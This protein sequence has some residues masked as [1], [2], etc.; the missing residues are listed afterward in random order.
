MRASAAT[1]RPVTPDSS[2]TIVV[3]A[4]VIPQAAA[5]RMKKCSF[6]TSF[7]KPDGGESLR[8]AGPR[9]VTVGVLHIDALTFGCTPAIAT[10]SDSNDEVNSRN[11]S[12]KSVTMSVTIG[13]RIRGSH[14]SGTTRTSPT[15]SL[16]TESS[17][18]KWSSADV[19]VAVSATPRRTPS[20][21]RPAKK[22]GRASPPTSN[23]ES[24][25]GSDHAIPPVRPVGIGSR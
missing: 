19:F 14:P 7:G 22:A 11:T 6:S 17:S 16:P 12:R 3:E 8:I 23:G 13:G 18:V 1:R 24:G 2:S 25:P 9:S 15:V 5:I 21:S 20:G 10:A 4:A